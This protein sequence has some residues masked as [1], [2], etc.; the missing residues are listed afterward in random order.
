MSETT[1]GTHVGR[2]VISRRI[3]RG[4]FATVWKAR[5]RQGGDKAATSAAAVAV[6]DVDTTKL[7]EKLKENLELEVGIMR[8]LQHPHITQL[9]E[10]HHTDASLLL[11]LEYC[12]CG[13]L[14][15]LIQREPRPLPEGLALHFVQ[16]LAE[17]LRYVRMRGVIHRDLKPQNLLLASPPAA[18]RSFDAS[19]PAPFYRSLVLKIADFGFARWVQPQ[20][21]VETLCGSPLY[22]APEVLAM[23]PYDAKADLW[24]VGTILFQLLSKRTPYSGL[25]YMDL[26]KNIET[27]RWQLPAGVLR[28]PGAITPSCLELL[29]ALLQHD[30]QAR[31]SFDAMFAHPW[32]GLPPT[33][34][35]HPEVATTLTTTATPPPPPPAIGTTMGLTMDHGPAIG[36]TMGLTMDHGPAIGTM[37]LTPAQPGAAAAAPPRISIA[38]RSPSVQ[39]LPPAPAPWSSGG[40]GG[41]GGGDGVGAAGSAS[42]AAAVAAVP[43]RPLLHGG[44]GEGG[45]AREGGRG[46]RRRRARG[47][48]QQQ[49]RL[50]VVVEQAEVVAKLASV[51]SAPSG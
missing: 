31:C 22:M 49:Q 42:R 17:G 51:R 44:G 8:S 43:E 48:R 12:N 25:N 16:Q 9:L 1:V 45:L 15:A 29:G 39:S 19:N 38:A 41:G 5:A 30:P 47:R 23:K 26:L 32:L 28:G 46:R 20:S 35:P 24:S 4:S 6:K 7:T 21:L 13:D 11:V 27:T 14:H 33:P 34:P 10:V 3:G 50:G 37:G 36:T 2:Y 40:G 18:P